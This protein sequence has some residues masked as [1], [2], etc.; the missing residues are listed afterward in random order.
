MKKIKTILMLVVIAG[1]STTISCTKEG[2]KGQD[3]LNGI[4]GID[5]TNGTDGNANVQ[6]FN[7]TVNTGDWTYDNLYQRQYYQYSLTAN[8]NS[9]V[10]C[11]VMSGSGKQIMPYYEAVNQRNYDFANVLY[12]SSP[13]IEFQYTDYTSTTTP[14]SSSKNFY[15]VII[16]ARLAN[17]DIDY[18]NYNEVKRVFN[19]KD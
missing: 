3:G 13:Y 14:P 8:Y 11:Y 12:Q 7:I 5:G 1:I 19:L 10:V 9:L 6:N 16:P 4:N 2:E 15:I 18:S 17:P